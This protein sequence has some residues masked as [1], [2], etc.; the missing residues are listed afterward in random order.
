[1]TNQKYGSERA[2]WKAMLKYADDQ[3]LTKAEWTA[4]SELTL[5]DATC[6]GQQPLNR[7]STA[8]IPY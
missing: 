4:L 2:T 7:P 3:P 1:M 8:A 5:I 6:A